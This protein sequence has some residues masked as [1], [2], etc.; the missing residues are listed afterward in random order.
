MPAVAEYFL[1]VSI[2]VSVVCLLYQLLFKRLTFYN[3]NRYFLLI[4]SVFAFL[5]PFINVSPALEQ[6]NISNNL[7]VQSIPVLQNAS[8]AVAEQNVELPDTPGIWNAWNIALCIIAAGVVVMLV[9]F[10]AQLLSLKR[11]VSNATLI[12]GGGAK[13]YQLDKNIPPFSFGRS[14]FIN[15][16]LHDESDL[17]GIIQ[18]EVVHV[19]QRHTIDILWAELLCVINWYNPFAW[20]LKNSIKQNL[21]FI[22]D[23][24][25]IEKGASKKDYQ[26]LLLKAVGSRYLPV[27][28]PFNFSS[29]KKRI[30][31]MNQAKSARL[32]LL[33]FLFIIP[34]AAVVLLSFRKVKQQPGSDSVYT[35]MG[36]LFDEVTLQPIPDG[37]V[38]DSVSGI[39]SKTNNKG[40]Y[41]LIV[42]RIAGKD[43]S[44]RFQ[45]LKQGYPDIT[46]GG[47]LIIKEDTDNSLV[48]LLGKA[49]IKD[50]AS[51]AGKG[52]LIHS[53]SYNEA[54]AERMSY[55]A[56][57]AYQ[58]E[59]FKHN[60][61]I[62]RRVENNPHPIHIIDGIPNA[63]G[64]GSRAWFS[65]EEVEASP[66]F[67]VWADGKIMTMEE[68]N[69][70]FNRFE[71][72]G[73]GASPKASAK[74]TFGLD[75]NVLIIY[76]DSIP[77]T[78]P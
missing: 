4:N 13:I 1:K 53:L 6:G 5:L 65:K 7:F 76:K 44:I 31:K 52:L 45:I 67:K 55:D 72:K 27:A 2:G 66:T 39:S 71:L 20:W 16:H 69:A 70:K 30:V 25:V 74:E 51:G 29:L 43:L 77:P 63:F 32:H 19:Q 9:R 38:K 22:A 36:V 78:I 61:E 75:C 8:S 33:K 18:H 37:I 28:S 23:N 12:D 26:Y 17:E 46:A 41:K 73:I 14:V 50:I 34:L 3:W 11:L 60:R 40:F 59:E 57:L 48:V 35:V 47:I 10:V 62:D 56:Y 21:E 58:M 15:R 49:T 64:N 24:G 68:A 42:P 54:Q